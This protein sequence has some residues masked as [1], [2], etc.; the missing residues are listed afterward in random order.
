MSRLL[1]TLA[2]ATCTF[3][4][5]AGFAAPAFS[6]DRPEKPNVVL[7]LADDLGWQD[8]GCYDIDEPCPYETPNIDRLSQQG[9]LFRQAYSPAPTC[10]PSR[11]A[12]LSGKHPAR[13]Q[14]TH[15]VGGAPPSPHAKNSP[16]ISPWYRGR[17]KLSEITIAEALRENG[18]RTG[19]AGKWHVAIQHFAFPQPV[20]QGFDFSLAERG[21]TRRMR[22]DRLSGFASDADDDPYQLDEDGFPFHQN[23]TNAV[24]FMDESKSQPFFLYHATYLVHA[25]I[26]SRSERL[27]RKY[28]EKMNVPFPSDPDKWELE[29]QR[30]PFYGA[31][32]E[33]L[34]HYV[35]K[36]LRYLETTEDP[37]WPGHRLSENTYVIFTS[38]NGGMEQHPGEIITD[39]YPLDKGKINAK[40]GG[41]RVPLII[42]GPGIAPGTESDVMVNGLDF[43]PTILSWTGTS[44]PA[45]QHLDGADLSSLLASDP[46]DASMI[47]DRDGKPRDSMFWHFPHSSMQST[48]RVGGYKLIRNWSDVLQ[49]GSNPLELYHLYDERNQRVDIEESNNLAAEMPEKAAAMNEELQK[50][51][52]ETAASPPFLNPNC[53]RRLPR[54]DQVCEVS[55]HGRD[56][57]TVWAKFQTHGAKVVKANLI[58]TDNGGERY[59][60]WY[61]TPAKINGDRVQVELP[62]GATHYVFNL[63]DENH[64]LVSYPTM[65]LGKDSSEKYSKRAIAK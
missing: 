13:T 48:L 28:C 44:K 31:M 16:L 65:R 12:I 21:V 20:D 19:H 32:V 60:E 30:N 36:V 25:P 4:C 34:D 37:R 55:D 24:E 58:Y 3:L 33:M 53:S 59:E 15:V 23:V 45:Q 2:L 8:V 9:V 64:Y 56:G 49:D 41:V 42:R 26:H 57:N 6:Q 40:E 38:D 47:V 29:G 5:A 50:R 46:K 22:P 11:A 35:G 63:I 54:Q 10:A 61:R 27:L 62:E 1:T 43:Y 7:L 52:D 14:K 39:N 17:M 18:Y 51:L